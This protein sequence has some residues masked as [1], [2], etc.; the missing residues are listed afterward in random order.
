MLNLAIRLLNNRKHLLIVVVL[1]ALGKRVQQ[2]LLMHRRLVGDGADVGILHLNVETL[3]LGQVEELVVDV[4]SVL[5]I[6][7]EADDG[8]A[9]KLLGLVHH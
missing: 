6:F 8:K 4:V 2:V 5:H 9:F 1:D 3:L 7:F